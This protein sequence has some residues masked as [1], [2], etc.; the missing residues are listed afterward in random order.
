MFWDDTFQTFEKE[1]WNQILEAFIFEGVC[2]RAVWASF[3]NRVNLQ[4]WLIIEHICE[5]NG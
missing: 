1:E 4:L 2:D 5:G 3:G